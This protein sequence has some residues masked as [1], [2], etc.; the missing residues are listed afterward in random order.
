[1][2]LWW[3]RFFHS[4]LCFFGLLQFF[5]SCWRFSPYFQTPRTVKELWNSHQKPRKSR[6]RNK[7]WANI[8]LAYAAFTCFCV[9]IRFI[10]MHHILPPLTK[11][12]PHYWGIGK[13]NTGI[14]DMLKNLIC[15]CVSQKTW[16]ENMRTFTLEIVKTMP[17]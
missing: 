8:S 9:F 17:V 7:I 2:V 12:K 11:R 13:C 4:F 16:L 10:L 5:Y 1:M 14:Q 6:Q 3:F 15:S